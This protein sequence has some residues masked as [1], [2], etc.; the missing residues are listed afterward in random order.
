MNPHRC[1]TH[2]SRVAGRTQFRGTGPSWC[3][4]AW[5]A[6]QYAGVTGNPLPYTGVMTTG[7]CGTM[8]VMPI[9]GTVIG[10]DC[11]TGTPFPGDIGAPRVAG[12]TVYVGGAEYIGAGYVGPECIGVEYVG[13]TP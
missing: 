8:C 13:G 10:A 4:L 11:G 1:R 12:G 6:T 9:G 7:D 3:S 2:Y 5:F